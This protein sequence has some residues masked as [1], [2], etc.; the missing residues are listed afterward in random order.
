M[1]LG[2]KKYICIKS[3]M[4]MNPTVFYP[5][6]CFG[7]CRQWYGLYDCPNCGNKALEKNR[8]KKVLTTMLK[9]HLARQKYHLFDT[10]LP[11][12]I[13]QYLQRFY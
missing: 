3:S 2:L 12:D 6:A 10:V 8:R 11:S 1:C 9:T 5:S 13:V 7:H 4:A